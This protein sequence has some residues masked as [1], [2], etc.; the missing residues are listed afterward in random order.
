MSVL[1]EPVAKGG[2]VDGGKGGGGFKE[3]EHP[4]DGKGEFTNKGG[5]SGDKS[6]GSAAEGEKGSKGGKSA[7]GEQ[8]E[9][10]AKPAELKSL[11]RPG[12]HRA[13]DAERKALKI[14]PAWTDVHVADDPESRLVAL[15]RDKAGRQQPRYSAAHTEAALAEKFERGR[16]FN[17]ALPGILYHLHQE[18][19][20]GGKRREEA[21]CL[22]LIALSGFRVGG[23]E[24]TGAK[25]KAYGAST[26]ERQHVKIEGETVHFD[27]PGK[28]GVRQQHSI[29]DAELAADMQARLDSGTQ[30]LFKTNDAKLRD[31]LKQAAGGQAF[32]VHDLRTWNATETARTAVQE[33]EPPRSGE[34]YWEKRDQAATRA[35]R[36]IGDTVD[37][38]LESYIDPLVFEDWRTQVG[39]AADA[40]RPA[41]KRGKAK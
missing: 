35:A 4:R 7:A 33:I 18:I 40:Q 17:A 11:A 32:K 1:F 23:A 20:E 19:A 2:F 38:A 31:Y 37:V 30:R 9:A 15:G 16:A 41:K 6:G 26:L 27:F 3:D 39:V 25:V 21:A 24:D 29:T 5:G 12:F 22:R 8:G 36:K 28:K 13:T 10:D 14:P 34:E